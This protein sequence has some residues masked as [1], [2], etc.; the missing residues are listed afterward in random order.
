MN[1]QDFVEEDDQSRDSLSSNLDWNDR[2]EIE[3]YCKK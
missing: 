3:K 1:A 2:G